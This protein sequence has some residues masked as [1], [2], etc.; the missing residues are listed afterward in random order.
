MHIPKIKNPHNLGERFA[1][2]SKA[3]PVGSAA[4]EF[5]VAPSIAGQSLGLAA[6]ALPF[7]VLLTGIL[8]SLVLPNAIN[9]IGQ[10]VDQRSTLSAI[11]AN[12]MAPPPAYDQV[13]LDQK[14][15]EN[16]ANSTSNVLLI[17]GLTELSANTVLAQ[18]YSAASTLKPA[19]LA[20]D[21]AFIDL[22]LLPASAPVLITQLSSGGE[23]VITVIDEVEGSMYIADYR[24]AQ[25]VSETFINTGLGTLTVT[26]PATVLSTLSLSGKVEFVGAGMEVTTGITVSGTTDSSDVALYIHGGANSGLGSTDVINLGDGNNVVFD[27]G[28]GRILINLGGGSNSVILGGTGVSGAVHFASHP[29]IVSN[30]I[31]IAPN[32]KENAQALSAAPLVAVSG[33]NSGSNSSDIGAFLGDLNGDLLWA[34]GSAQSAHVQLGDADLHNLSFWVSAAQ[35]KASQAHSLAWF[36]FEGATYVLETVNGA[37]GVRTSDTLVKFVGAVTFT[38][39][40]GELTQDILHLIG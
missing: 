1:R 38:G 23:S 29:D 16:L 26:T 31:A 14:A 5:V 20:I 11:D 32:G 15:L 12:L 37:E 21:P 25:A 33:L 6:S 10:V 28:D 22:S 3:P 17:S 4:T 19:A 13:G 39:V 35:S 2:L 34:G 30:F 24:L 36:Q 40:S 7:G 18:E 8:D 9:A 27:V